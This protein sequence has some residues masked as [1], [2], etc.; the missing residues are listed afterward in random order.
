MRDRQ[1]CTGGGGVD[2]SA[3]LVVHARLDY[4]GRAAHVD[5]HRCILIR[6]MILSGISMKV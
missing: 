2:E 4:V 1:E 5:L 6:L 3:D